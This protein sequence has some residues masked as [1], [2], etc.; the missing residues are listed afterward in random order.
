MHALA[1]RLEYSDRTMAFQGRRR[2]QKKIDG[3]GN[4]SQV[5]Q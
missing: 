4:R 3:L 5:G 1:A 2:E